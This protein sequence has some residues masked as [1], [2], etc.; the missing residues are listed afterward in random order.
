MME[1]CRSVPDERLAFDTFVVGAC[2]AEAFSAAKSA[3][4]GEQHGLLVLWSG[5]GLGKTHLLRAIAAQAQ[6]RLPTEQV[7][8][9]QTD[10]Y[11]AE[12][13]AAIRADARAAFADQYRKA[14]VFLLDDIQSAAGKEQ[15]QQELGAL[16]TALQG[17][18][19][20]V[21]LTSDRP[22]EE[23]GACF[24]KMLAGCRAVKLREADTATRLDIV[25]HKAAEWGFALQE[26]ELCCIAEKITGSVCR[27]EGVLRRIMAL[28]EL[29]AED[30]CV[31]GVVED[32]KRTTV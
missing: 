22:P 4:A 8:Y 19:C 5:A 13:I 12:L 27:M 3:A 28:R 15:T 24:A 23:L 17:K 11:I 2:N 30:V 29:G 14:A 32:V 31:E 20:T 25:R 9:L 18:G 26:E 16:L 10:T 1:F 21:V 6:K 7:V